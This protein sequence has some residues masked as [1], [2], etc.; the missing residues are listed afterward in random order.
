[1]CPYPA[2]RTS[3]PSTVPPPHPLCYG[4]RIDR[5][6]RGSSLSTLGQYIKEKTGL[7]TTIIVFQCT[8]DVS[9]SEWGRL[10]STFCGGRKNPP[11]E[12]TEIAIEPDKIGKIGEATYVV[13]GTGA[14][15]RVLTGPSC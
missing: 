11:R 6:R 10:A 13:R 8:L 14:S 5:L 3:S 12:G 15:D 1:M 2:I 9:L 4:A 7:L